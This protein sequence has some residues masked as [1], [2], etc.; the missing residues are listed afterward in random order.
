MQKPLRS[1]SNLLELSEFYQYRIPKTDKSIRPGL[2]PTSDIAEHSVKIPTQFNPVVH[3]QS[4]PGSESDLSETGSPDHR[5]RQDSGSDYF[6][7]EGG[8]PPGF[9][10]ISDSKLF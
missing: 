10:A 5:A 9:L 1:W 3:V 7:D 6:G 4:G 8:D 2:S